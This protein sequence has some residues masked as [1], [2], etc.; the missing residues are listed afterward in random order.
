MA[1]RQRNERRFPNW[2]E[3]PDGGRRYYE[4]KQ[5]KKFGYAK[6]VKIVDANEITL[7]IVQ[8]IYDDNGRL[9][10]LH[11]KYPIDT[12]HQNVPVEGKDE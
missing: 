8:E 7:S 9:V 1:T 12:G 2:D 3:L 5:G 4:I 11:Q 6:Y 10:A